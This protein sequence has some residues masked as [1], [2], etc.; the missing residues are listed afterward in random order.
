[1]FSSMKILHPF[2]RKYTISFEAILKASEISVT[3]ISQNITFCCKQNF[4][5]Q[6]CL[7]SFTCD[8]L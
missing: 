5:K 8:R 3:E 4:A 1:M 2:L 6:L 7:Q